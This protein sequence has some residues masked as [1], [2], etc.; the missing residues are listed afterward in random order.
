M[1][2]WSARSKSDRKA[3]HLVSTALAKSKKIFEMTKSK[4]IFEMNQGTLSSSS[5]DTLLATETTSRTVIPSS[6]TKSGPSHLSVTK[7]TKSFSSTK[8][9]SITVT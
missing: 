7:G 3:S 9:L 1:I 4:K 2:P 8:K 6:A 5:D